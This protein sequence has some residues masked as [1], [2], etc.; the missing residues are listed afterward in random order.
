VSDTSA[1]QLVEAQAYER[2][3]EIKTS[4]GTGTA[5]TIDYPFSGTGTAPGQPDEGGRQYLITAKHLL[6]PSESH[7]RVELENRFFRAELELDLLAVSP[8]IADVALAPLERPLTASLYL[9]AGSQGISFSQRLFFLGF[10]YGMA[11]E[12]TGGQRMAFVKG[13]LLSASAEVAGE[14]LLYLDGFNNCGFSGGPV[15]AWI[16]GVLRVVGVISGYR[17]E[18]VAAYA[19]GTPAYEG[20]T[21]TGIEVRANTGIV[22][23]TDI[24]HAVD[25]IE[26][27]L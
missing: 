7:P 25:A 17:H 27:L 4:V 20:Q 11:L 14:K 22:I 5:F 8:A 24:A 26:R 15:V 18:R 13:G 10:P 2:V 21:V 3:L 19:G 1:S 23:A 9:P 6:P 16:D 12:A